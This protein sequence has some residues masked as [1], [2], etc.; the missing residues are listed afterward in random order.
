MF[1]LTNMDI[2]QTS[3]WQQCP[4]PTNALVCYPGQYRSYSGHCNNV[5]NPDWGSAYMP[6]KRAL[7]PRYGDGVSK[8]RR[9]ITGA[10]LPSA[11]DVSLAVHQGHE[12]TYSHITTI[13]SFFGQFIFNDL[14]HVAQSTGYKGQ[15]IRCC[16]LKKAELVHPECYPIK[17]TATDPFMQKLNQNCMEYIRSSPTIRNHCSL[18]PREQINQAS[19]LIC[20][21]KISNNF[22]SYCYFYYYFFINI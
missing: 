6:F 14:A 20:G 22:I 11:R 10:E 9:S 21:S 19:F 3:L 7:V 17:I 15:R 18:G 1:G 5:E 4:K 2:A 12:S 16:G 13:T 8:V